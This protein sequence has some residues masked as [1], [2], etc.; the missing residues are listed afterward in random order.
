ML[1]PG[2]REEMKS[3][4]FLHTSSSPTSLSRIASCDVRLGQSRDL[5]LLI[6]SGVV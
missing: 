6:V 3:Y 4:A 5:P 1:E 2:S